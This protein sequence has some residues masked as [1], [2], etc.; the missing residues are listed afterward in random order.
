VIKKLSDEKDRLV[1]ILRGAFAGQKDVL[2][3]KSKHLVIKSPHPSPFSADRGFF[4]S[5]PFS[6]TNARL[7]E[8]G[9]SVI[10]W[11]ISTD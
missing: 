3:D 2:I 7:Q 5:K 6:K 10:D 8:H 11:N 1:F 4:G 9:M